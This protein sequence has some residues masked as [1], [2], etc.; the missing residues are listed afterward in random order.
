MLALTEVQEGI[1]VR[2][3][4]RLDELMKFIKLSAK[5]MGNKELEDRIELASQVIRRDI[6]F[7]QSLYTISDNSSNDKENHH[8]SDENLSSNFV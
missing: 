5:L 4:Q 7:C 2:T 6:V 1:I 8:K 3:I